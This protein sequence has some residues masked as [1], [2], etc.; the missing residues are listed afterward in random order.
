[1]RLCGAKTPSFVTPRRDEERLCR[2]FDFRQSRGFPINGGLMQRRGGTARHDAVAWGYARA[3]LD[4]RGRRHHPELRGHRVSVIERRPAS[5]GGR[6][7][8][9]GFIEAATKLGAGGCRPHLG[10]GERKWR[11]C[12]MPIESHVLQAFVS[13]GLKPVH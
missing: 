8:A 13:E 5:S 2:F 7:H 11:G 4:M 9:C 1:M 3:A 12:R 10:P 6:D